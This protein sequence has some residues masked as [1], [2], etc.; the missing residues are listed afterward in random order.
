MSSL[1]LV[2]SPQAPE[3]AGLSVKRRILIVDD[4]PVLLRALVRTFMP[5]RAVWEIKTAASAEEALELMAQQPFDVVISDMRMPGM[6]GDA[7]LEEVK[8][9]Y[10]A[11]VRMIHSGEASD[12]SRVRSC[13]TAHQFLSKPWDVATVQQSLTR[14]FGLLSAIN[15]DAVREAISGVTVLPSQIQMLE[16]LRRVVASERSNSRQLVEVVSSDVALT[17]KLLQTVNSAFFGIARRIT[18]LDEAVTYLGSSMVRSLAQATNVMSSFGNA[19]LVDAVQRKSAQVAQVAKSIAP[20][21]LKDD[22]F[23]TGLLHDVGRLVMAAVDRPMAVL[24]NHA[25]VGAYLL[26]SWGLPW[27]VVEAV[28]SY[29]HVMLDGRAALSLGDIVGI[30]RMFVDDPVGAKTRLLGSER[31]GAR[32]ADVETWDLQ[33]KKQ[34]DR[35]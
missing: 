34:R 23:A 28:G 20:A 10:P 8:R 26:Q 22:A 32:A 7:L 19:A 6:E 25:H 13:G 11:T 18:N 15:D 35:G 24:P 17:A 3:V 5:F 21:L 14:I 30:A 29:P 4:E 1:A 9:R 27:S 16:R 12:E 31:F 33:A 2:A